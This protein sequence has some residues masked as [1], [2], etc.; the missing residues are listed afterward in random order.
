MQ[1]CHSLRRKQI[2]MSTADELK[3]TFRNNAGGTCTC[4]RVKTG[5]KAEGVI[6]II[7]CEESFTPPDVYLSI[8]Q[9]QAG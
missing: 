5:W 4:D 2:D 6:M 7:E 9:A 1:M 8:L 3:S